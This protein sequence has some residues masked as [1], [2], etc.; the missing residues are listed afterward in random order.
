[1]RTRPLSLAAA[2]ILLVAIDLRLV[3]GDAAPDAIGW[4]LV[5]FAAH[6][7]GMRWPTLLAAAAAVASLAEVHL[8]YEWEAYDLLS[9]RVIPNPDPNSA[10]DER[11]VF[12][13]VE[14]PRLA[15]MVGALALGGAALTMVLR[16]LRRGAAT[17]TD[18]RGTKALKILSWM[19]PLGWIG[20][21]VAIAIGWTIN[22]GAFDPVWNDHWELVA[23]VGIAIAVAVAIVFATNANRRWSAS[24][25][26]IGSPWAELMLR[27]ADQQSP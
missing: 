13:P 11:L 12:L 26:E 5:A 7:L 3:A 1:V 15:M 25:D 16:E 27:D 8:P 2:G 4:A 24:G 19:V 17:T 18:H 20:P 9:G 10:Y 21:Y 14:G 6:R 22:E 23:L